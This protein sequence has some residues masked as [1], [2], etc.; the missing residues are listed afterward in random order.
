MQE[1]IK[2]GYLANEFEEFIS[3]EKEDYNLDID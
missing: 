3:F 1:I 2:K